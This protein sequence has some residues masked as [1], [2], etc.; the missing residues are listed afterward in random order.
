MSGSPGLA[1]A[2][3][4]GYG[5]GGTGIVR[6]QRELIDAFLDHQARHDPGG[7]SLL[8]TP[9]NRS[10]RPA[11]LPATCDHHRSRHPGKLQTL[12]N[13]RLGLPIETLLPPLARVDL[14]HSL[15]PEAIHTR[16]PWLVTV[17]DVAW[18]SQGPGYAAVFPRSMQRSAEASIRAASHLVAVSRFTADELITGGVAPRRIS[19][20]YQ[21]IPQ[22]PATDAEA[23][24]AASILAALELPDRFV[25]SVG[26][27]HP[28]KNLALIARAYARA[29]S[30][31]LLPC[32]LVGPPPPQPLAA[33]GVDGQRLRHLGYLDDAPL[34]ALLRRATALIFP[35]RHEGF[36]RPLIEAMAL[37][38]PVVASS[39]PVFREL[40]GDDAL[41]VDLDAADA[42]RQLARQ[43]RRLAADAALAADLGARGRRRAVRFSWQHCCDEL[44]QLYLQWAA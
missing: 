26:T 10:A 6:Y 22:P 16:R 18:R 23:A 12:A 3:A 15:V 36:G 5:A 31:D 41:F 43:L 32:L 11:G 30:A 29:D 35:S 9:F 37:G 2:F 28:R 42:D 1:V 4:G 14:I 44:Q 34:A 19:V 13:Q 7:S 40:A 39:I 21:G 20:I 27:F 24:D 25:L 17:H 8:F 38:L 33:L